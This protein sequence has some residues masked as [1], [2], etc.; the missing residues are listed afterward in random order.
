MPPPFC[1]RFG[2]RPGPCAMFELGSLIVWMRTGVKQEKRANYWLAPNALTSIDS[3]AASMIPS[4]TS[5]NMSG[6]SRNTKRLA[7]K[8]PNISEEPAIRPFSAISRRQRA[9]TLEG[10][11]FAQI[12]AERARRFGGK[13]RALG[14]AVEQEQRHAQRPGRNHDA[15]EIAD[16]GAA[17][18]KMP[19]REFELMPGEPMPHRHHRDQEHA[20]RNIDRVRRQRQQ[21]A[22]AERRGRNAGDRIGGA[23]APVDLAPPGEDARQVGHARLRPP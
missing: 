22:G 10:H 7:M 8:A 4:I 23:G 16:H 20:D 17:D 6:S 2:S 3:P 18:R 13:E 12:E 15:G 11:R 21:G 19:E 1:F 14:E 9:E 5:R